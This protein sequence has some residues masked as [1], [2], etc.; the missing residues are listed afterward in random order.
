MSPPSAR[1][2]L[3]QVRAHALQGRL[4]LSHHARL[5]M[6]ERGALA[7]DVTNAAWTETAATFQED[8]RTWRVD[9]G[10]DLDGDALCLVVAPRDDG[11]LVVTLM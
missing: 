8:H 9:G 6:R 10:V 11:T 3:D 2:F 4:I 1:E 7:E 5:R